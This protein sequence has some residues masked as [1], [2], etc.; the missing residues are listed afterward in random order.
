MLIKENKYTH[1]IFFSCVSCLHDPTMLQQKPLTAI[2]KSLRRCIRGDIFLKCLPNLKH[3]RK[4]LSLSACNGLR[5]VSPL[6]E[7][8]SKGVSLLKAPFEERVGI[9]SGS[10][11]IRGDTLLKCLPN[12][13]YLRKLLLLS[14]IKG[15]RKVSPLA[16]VP[17]NS[18]A[19]PDAD[20]ANTSRWLTA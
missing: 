15:L 17:T 9:F 4:G 13:K 19:M 8:S 14:A 12:L 5:K 11:R 2:R 6:A 10:V 7:E 1:L 3:L 20:F 16:E 18:A